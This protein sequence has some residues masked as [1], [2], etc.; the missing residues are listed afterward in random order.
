VVKDYQ[1]PEVFI[2]NDEWSRKAAIEIFATEKP[3]VL[4]VDEEDLEKIGEINLSLPPI[5]NGAS[6]AIEV[7]MLFGDTKLKVKAKNLDSDDEVAADLDFLMMHK[8]Q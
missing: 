4:F 7:S 2:D 3:E 6:R 8:A 5:R 1:V